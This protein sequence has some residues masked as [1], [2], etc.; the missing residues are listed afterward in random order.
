MSKDLKYYHSQ[1]HA[2]HILV[3]NLIKEIDEDLTKEEEQKPRP[4]IQSMLKSGIGKLHKPADKKK[5]KEEALE[6]FSKD[7]REHLEL[8]AKARALQKQ[9]NLKRPPGT[10]KT[11][12]YLQNQ[13]PIIFDG[14]QR[15]DE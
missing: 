13:D 4:E 15:N 8:L 2:I 9:F 5:E 3:G 14:F 1:L 12:L 10:T 11:Q 7:I 6:A